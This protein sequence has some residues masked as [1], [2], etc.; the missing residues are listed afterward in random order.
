MKAYT[1]LTEALEDSV[2]VTNVTMRNTIIKQFQIILIF[3]LLYQ[4]KTSVNI[5]QHAYLPFTA[6]KVVLLDFSLTVKA[7]PHECVIR[8]SQP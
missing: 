2:N 1:Y 5:Y 7:V 8:T 4:L 6:T 3:I